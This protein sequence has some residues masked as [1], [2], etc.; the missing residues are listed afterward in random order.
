MPGRRMVLGDRWSLKDNQEISRL[1]RVYHMGVADDEKAL[2]G[3]QEQVI[4]LLLAGKKQRDA[5]ESAGVAEETVSRWMHGDALFVATLNAR[6]QDL[7]Q[8]TAERLLGLGGKAAATLE[9]LLDSESESTRLQAA[10]AVLKA[11]GLD[12]G[13]RPVAE[14][15]PQRIEREWSRAAMMDALLDYDFR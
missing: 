7:W 9:G 11:Q 14:T 13:G 15:D 12:A 8:A 3:Q 4:A 1:W 5:A 6:R 10:K 2:T